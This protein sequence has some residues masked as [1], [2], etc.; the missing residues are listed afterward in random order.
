MYVFSDHFYRKH[1][2]ESLLEDNWELEKEKKV[3]G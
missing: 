2:T 1:S 3:E